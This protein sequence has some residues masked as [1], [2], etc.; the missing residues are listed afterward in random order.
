MLFSRVL[1]FE[2]RWT[3]YSKALWSVEVASRH[4][5]KLPPFVLL[6]GYRWLWVG[7][8]ADCRFAS[9]FEPV[10]CE[11]FRPRTIQSCRAV[12]GHHHELLMTTLAPSLP[13]TPLS[14]ALGLLS[15]PFFLDRNPS[16]PDG[17]FSLSSPLDIAPDV[18]GGS[19]S[20]DQLPVP[21]RIF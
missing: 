3:S 21:C 13:S 7:A 15:L 11:N 8:F 12:R 17:L 14:L 5:G 16:I 9:C 4:V 2:S 10:M 18:V 19:P 20:S 1:Y 6:D